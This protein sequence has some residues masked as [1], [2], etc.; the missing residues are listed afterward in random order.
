M[1]AV[2]GQQRA[3]RWVHSWAHRVG[4]LGL[5]LQL[6]GCALFT[7]IPGPGQAG[8]GCQDP[9]LVP[10]DKPQLFKLALGDGIRQYWLY[11]PENVDPSRPAPLVLNF[12]GL[13][14]SALEQLEMS[15]LNVTARA[16]GFMVAYPEGTEGSWNG[17]DCCG[18]AKKRA[19]DD[20]GFA[21]AVVQ[22]TSSRI[23]VDTTRI[24]ATGMANGA[25]MS[26]RLACEASDLFAAVAPVAGGF[27]LRSCRPSRPVPVLAIHGTED[28]IIPLSVAESSYRDW[29]LFDE[30][31]LGA[32]SDEGQC[33]VNSRCPAGVEVGL[34]RLQGV[35]H[36]W[37]GTE[38]C[39]QGV[40]TSPL[41]FS[42]NVEMWRFFERL[43]RQ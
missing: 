16:R 30:C 42:A 40:S 7:S 9:T 26:H 17:G 38:E 35:G 11:V 20:V 28:E 18:A 32:E 37:P 14:S 27:Y 6:V 24:Y 36:C 3:S 34:C 22:D 15:K 13:N 39:A 19:I 4:L 21:R 29:Q 12:H 5:C 31:R 2:P 23:C 25:M 1:R 10:S 43:R 8:L 33:S 41:D